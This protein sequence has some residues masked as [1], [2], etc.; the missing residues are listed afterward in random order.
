MTRRIEPPRHEEHQAVAAGSVLQS[1]SMLFNLEPKK[2]AW[3][4]SCLGGSIH[5]HFANRFPLNVAQLERQRR[6]LTG[7]ID[8]DQA[9]VRRLIALADAIDVRLVQ[10]AGADGVQTAGGHVV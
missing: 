9:E 3:W 8:L 5:L 7:P 4:S 1:A 2:T 6:R 10:R